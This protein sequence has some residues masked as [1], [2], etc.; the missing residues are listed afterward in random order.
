MVV[1]KS[2]LSNIIQNSPEISAQKN[3]I[4]TSILSALTI[5]PFDVE[6]TSFGYF[7][8]ILLIS[9]ISTLISIITT[10]MESKL[11][12]I[13]DYAGIFLF[14]YFII[15]F[16]LSICAFLHS[17]FGCKI[18]GHPNDSKHLGIIASS[19]SAFPILVLICR[20]RIAILNQL[21]SLALAMLMPYYINST[22]QRYFPMG[23]D[24]TRFIYGVYG[25]IIFYAITE[26]TIA[27]SLQYL[28]LKKEV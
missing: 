3:F 9:L 25:F 22:Y 17:Y 16:Y 6:N 18:L 27:L 13:Y 5:T 8:P 10:F 4:K 2:S 14:S 26:R 7:S 23:T 12:S 20:F 1:Q 15:F 24:R 21:S 11:P 19:F 28:P